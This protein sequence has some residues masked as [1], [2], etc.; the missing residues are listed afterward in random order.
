MPSPLVVWCLLDGKP[1]HENQSRGLLQALGKLLPLEV[2][3]I[4]APGI[5]QCL[6]HFFGRPSTQTPPIPQWIIGAG[7][8]THLG[9]LL[10]KKK[11]HAKAVVLM[12]PNFPYGWFDLC[13]V[14]EHDLP[15]SFPNV[16]ATKGVLNTIK[17]GGEHCADQGLI[18][19]GGES[20]H[21]HWSDDGLLAQIQ[22]IVDN[23]PLHWTISSSRRT[24]LSF[25][26]KIQQL[27]GVRL[28]WVPVE[29]T[30][31][32]W[33]NQHLAQCAKVWITED[34]VSMLY[35]ALTAGCQVGLLQ[36]P[37]KGETR[38]ARGVQ[39]VISDRWVTTFQQWKSGAVLCQA[40]AGF[41]EAGRCARWIVEAWAM[42]VEKAVT[43]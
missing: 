12:R 7:S 39:S 43:K 11:F 2:H 8:K 4:Q 25:A 21:F 35:E 29:E 6:Q 17:S 3:E 32:G 10:L 18:L 5:W 26:E 36:L 42:G 15:P 30:K 20:S 22:Q 37:P 41:H 23:D 1:G 40:P 33:V 38:V 14:P 24:P 9:L 19:I 13:I 28:Q 31:A 16:L 34:S 27:V